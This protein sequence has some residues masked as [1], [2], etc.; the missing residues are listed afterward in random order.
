MYATFMVTVDHGDIDSG[1][2]S[3]SDIPEVAA[4]RQACTTF[5]AVHGF[6][7]TRCTF[8]LTY[9]TMGEGGRSLLRP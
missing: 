1:F 4:W 9:R 5:S 7:A 3:P 8:M 6:G 2:A